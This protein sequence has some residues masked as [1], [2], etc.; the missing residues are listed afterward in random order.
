MVHRGQ[1]IADESLTLE[2]TATARET[3]GALHEMRAR[4]APGS[5]FP[6]AHHHPFQE[7]RFR[8]EEGELVFDIDGVEHVVDA[9]EEI[10]VPRRAVHRVRNGGAVPAVALWQT[11]PALRTGEF[12]ERVSR[13]QEAGNALHLLAVVGEFHDVY[14]LAVRPRRL[15]AGAVKLLV[16]VARRLTGADSPLRPAP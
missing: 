3:G 8:V 13:A 2:F 7:E 9:G 15:T 10:S 4:Y 5:P 14:Q 12:L 16:P 11:R 6:P 1:I